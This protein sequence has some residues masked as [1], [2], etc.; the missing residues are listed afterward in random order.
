[1]FQV[2]KSMS[3]VENV[4]NASTFYDYVYDEIGSFDWPIL[5]QDEEYRN[6]LIFY[7]PVLKEND[8]YRRSETFLDNLTVNCISITDKKE[9]QLIFTPTGWSG[10]PGCCLSYSSISVE[11]INDEEDSSNNDY[12][13]DDSWASRC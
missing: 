1:M 2:I 8:G 12:Y 3:K 10:S 11:V 7:N 5:L 6:T 13:S 4:Y 9:F